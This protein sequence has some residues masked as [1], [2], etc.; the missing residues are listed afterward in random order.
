M[1]LTKYLLAPVLAMS[2]ALPVFSSDKVN[3]DDLVVRVDPC[4]VLPV[5]VMVR[6]FSEEYI[7]N[8][9]EAMLTS[10]AF[11]H[12]VVE[13]GHYKITSRPQTMLTWEEECNILDFL[14]RQPDIKW[15]DF[16]C[17]LN[18][19]ERYKEVAA[20]KFNPT[21]GR[22]YMWVPERFKEILKKNINLRHLSFG[23]V[24]APEMVMEGLASHKKLRFL[25]AHF[26]GV[27]NE[28][29]EMVLTNCPDMHTL[30]IIGN[31][32]S[33]LDQGL[34]AILKK[35][36]Q[37]LREIDI[38]DCWSLTLNAVLSS[39]REMPKLRRIVVD[40]SK[41]PNNSIRRNAFFELTFVGE[42]VERRTIPRLMKLPGKHN[43]AMEEGLSYEAICLLEATCP[44]LKSL[45]LSYGRYTNAQLQA[46]GVL[47]PRLENLRIGG[48]G[49]E[50]LMRN[51]AAGH[52]ESVLQHLPMLESLVLCDI[53]PQDQAYWRMVRN[54]TKVL[55][56]SEGTPIGYL[57]AKEVLHA[58][59]LVKLIVGEEHILNFGGVDAL[60]A[61]FPHKEIVVKVKE[62]KPA[63]FFDPYAERE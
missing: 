57:S 42:E 26:F 17:S 10:K 34:S 63:E 59:N 1:R 37:G 24:P 9:K 4:E 48:R 36:G 39:V 49:V 22:K 53:L 51:Q 20:R 3:R 43:D 45:A 35:S 30:K 58:P 40:A 21:N 8:A 25:D 12:A 6:I 14:H 15:L 38:Q 33:P 54:H 11:F 50:F 55:D 52:T 23:L 7:E 61:E 56:V 19:L 16:G 41:L 32:E 31:S 62:K 5:E 2:M 44:P 29:V 60:R 28:F 27:S 18:L 13:R 47:C 46:I